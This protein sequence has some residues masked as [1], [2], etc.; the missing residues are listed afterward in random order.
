MRNNVTIAVMFRISGSSMNWGSFSRIV[1]KI[2]IGPLVPEIMRSMPLG[3]E[4]M[5]GNRLALMGIASK[6]AVADR[7]QA[8]NLWLI[9]YNHTCL[10]AEC[11]GST[12]LEAK[13]H[14]H[15]NISSKKQAITST[16]STPTCP[17]QLSSQYATWTP[18]TCSKQAQLTLRSLNARLGWEPVNVGGWLSGPSALFPLYTSSEIS[19]DLSGNDHDVSSKCW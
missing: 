11:S 18:G 16:K 17:H 8:A 10:R 14:N 19:V 7:F 9:Q 12:I 6:N 15:S 13:R 1:R 5:N 4:S 2:P 3:T